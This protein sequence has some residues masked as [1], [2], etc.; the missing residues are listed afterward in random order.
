MET[1][2]TVN[3]EEIKE[4]TAENG[5]EI[6]TG[7]TSAAETEAEKNAK[8]EEADGKENR[9]SRKEKKLSHQFQKEVDSLKE[10]L[11]EKNDQYLR[12]A[13]E[14]DNYRK[15]TDKEKGDCYVSAYGDALK[16]FLP[17]LD[18]LYQAQQYTPD[19]AGIKALVKQAEDI[20]SKLNIRAMETDGAT[21]D[22]VFHNAVMHEDNPDAG[23]NTIVQTFQRGYMLGDRVL[24]PAMVK[25]AN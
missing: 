8:T 23:E 9:G 6:S 19:D 11:A 25:V 18:V 10:R 15:R 1:E 14:Y 3:N 20:L 12:L 2:K 13:A 24:R 7:K 17:L 5:E 4:E 16:A 21:F 22:P